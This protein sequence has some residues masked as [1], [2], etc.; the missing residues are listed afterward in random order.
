EALSTEKFSSKVSEYYGMLQQSGV[1]LFVGSFLGIVFLL[2]MG[3]IIFFKMMTEAEE[4]K[5]LYEILHKSGVNDREMKRTIRHQML[6]V[7]LGPL[8]IGIAH[9]AI[10]LTAF[11]NLLMTNIVIPVILWMIGY[12]IIYIIFYFVTAKGFYKIIQEGE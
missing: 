6:F 12:T 3:S 5:P 8:L 9:A 1:L 7:F 4:D 11:S 10:A 2:A